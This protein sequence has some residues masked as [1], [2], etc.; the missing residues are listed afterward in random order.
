MFKHSFNPTNRIFYKIYEGTITIDDIK[1]SWLKLF[2][3]EII[4][5]EAIG[6]ILDYSGANF[7]LNLNEYNKIAEFYKDNLAY[8]M[9]TRI[10][11]ITN[12]PRDVVIPTLVKTLDDGYE[13]K[14]FSSIS[15]AEKWISEHK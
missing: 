5:E 8:F 15:N 2:N 11:I 4:P 14:P 3:E 7:S 6:F 10:G 9:N 1:T 12:N 13:S